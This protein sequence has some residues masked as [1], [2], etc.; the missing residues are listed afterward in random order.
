MTLTQK[1]EGATGSKFLTRLRSDYAVIFKGY[2]GY[3][4][5]PRRSRLSGCRFTITPGMRS[6]AR[7]AAGQGARPQAAGVDLYR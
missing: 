3:Q 7:C 1:Q 2:A 6:W 5:P 4:T